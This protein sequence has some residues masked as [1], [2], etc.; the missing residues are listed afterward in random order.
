M[1]NTLA[2]D[3]GGS[4]IKAIALD[5]EADPISERTR[6]S[7]PY[8]CPPE[9]FLQIVQ[10]LVAEQPACDRV[11]VGFPAMVRDGKTLRVVAFGRAEKDGPRDADLFALWDG[12]P[13]ERVLS[14]Q[15]NLPV[16]LVNDADMQGSA[17]ITGTGL[18]FV[19]TLGTGV[20]TS[21]FHNGQMLPH[22][23]LSH[24][25]YYGSSID[26]DLG[27]AARKKVGNKK[28]R[29]RVTKALWDFD[30]K[31]FPDSIFIGGGNAKILEPGDLL[32]HSAVVPNSAGLLGGV[33]IW[34][35]KG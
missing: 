19:M 33:K 9:L 29:E 2:I 23:E 27:N 30:A 10:Q 18:E 17:V 34:D 4:G 26:I 11:S 24:G 21:V 7:T 5:A 6:V 31:L 8:P 28:W 1:T 32:P 35:T 3:V 15:L 12:F 13:L 25:E 22:M 20:G 14:E 16:L